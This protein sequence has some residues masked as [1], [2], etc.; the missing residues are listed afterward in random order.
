MF[1]PYRYLWTGRTRKDEGEEITVAIIEKWFHITN[2][3]GTVSE[4]TADMYARAEGRK[5]ARDLV[6]KSGGKLLR[7]NL[8]ALRGFRSKTLKI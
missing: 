8:K 6:D 1:Q 3:G 2:E 4:T 5:F 7:Q